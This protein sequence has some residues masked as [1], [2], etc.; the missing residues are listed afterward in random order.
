M[1][2]T[3]TIPHDG[4]KI[5]EL[6]EDAGMSLVEL[7]KLTCRH[8]QSLRNIELGKSAS[9]VTLARIAKALKVDLDVIADDTPIEPAQKAS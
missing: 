8:P 2:E 4:G 6:R 3:N 5:R 1:P 9:K 7:G